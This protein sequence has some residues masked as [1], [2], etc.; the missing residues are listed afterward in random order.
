[1]NHPKETGIPR[2]EEG[3]EVIFSLLLPFLVYSPLD[4]G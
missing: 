4:G 3:K 1:L 2:E